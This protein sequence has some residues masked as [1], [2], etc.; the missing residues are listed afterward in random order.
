VVSHQHPGIISYESSVVRP[1][2]S[3]GHFA[4]NNDVRRKFC[5][6]HIR[7]KSWSASRSKDSPACAIGELASEFCVRRDVAALAQGFI[8]GKSE[9]SLDTRACSHGFPSA[10]ASSTP[11]LM[12]R[13]SHFAYPASVGRKNIA[14]RIR[15][16]DGG[17]PALK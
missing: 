2:C 5:S 8:A 15:F 10:A 12:P 13:C 16:A 9:I 3:P 7:S 17:E 11:C 1:F 6:H 4:K 14:L